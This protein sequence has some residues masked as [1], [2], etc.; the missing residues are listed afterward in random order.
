MVKHTKFVWIHL[1][2]ADVKN[3]DSN[4]EE[5]FWEVL[6]KEHENARSSIATRTIA[7]PFG[8]EQFIVNAE[9]RFSGSL[10]ETGNGATDWQIVNQFVGEVGSQAQSFEKRVIITTSR[11]YADLVAV[12]KAGRDLADTI[13]KQSL[14]S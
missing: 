3:E 7:N 12:Q 8:V 14:N 10:K 1:V 2:D 6:A 9:Q 5:K 11:D 13:A 4:Y